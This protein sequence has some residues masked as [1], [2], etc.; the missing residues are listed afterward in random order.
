MNEFLF[1]V[2]VIH[3]QYTSFFPSM[4]VEDMAD[5]YRLFTFVFHLFLYDVLF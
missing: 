5:N 1:D 4:L 3:K 2:F